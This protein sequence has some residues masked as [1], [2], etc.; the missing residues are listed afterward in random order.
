M[1]AL[2]FLQTMYGVEKQPSSSKDL[3]NAWLI[4]LSDIADA[5]LLAACQAHARNPE[6][7]RFWPTV[8]DLLAAAPNRPASIESRWDAMLSAHTR[9]LVMSDV[10]SADEERALHAI[11]GTW[12]LRR[13]D[14]E[15]D[16][17]GMR[18]RWI[19]A[20]RDGA[21]ATAAKQ[22]GAAHLRALPGGRS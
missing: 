13:A 20:V 22:I 5:D 14:V 2:T 19:A 4:V 1:T 3:A 12:A 18:K 10:L 17:P 21:D 16:L 6:A 11:G 15:R 9:H 8:A 7:G